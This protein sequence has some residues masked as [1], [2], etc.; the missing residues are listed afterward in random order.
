MA[1][2]SICPDGFYVYVHERNDSGSVFY[3]GKGRGKRA[4]TKRHYNS[5]WMRV[6]AK[7]GHTVRVVQS[8]LSEACAFSIERLMIY[9]LRATGAPLVNMTD[10]GEGP[11]GF[12]PSEETRLK[13]RAAKVGRKLAPEHAAKISAALR[14]K[15]RSQEQR[16]KLRGRIFSE[17]HKKA[18]SERATNRRMS[19]ESIAKM[20]LSKRGKKASEQTRA[21]NSAASKGEG[22]PH[23]SPTKHWFHHRVHGPRHCTQYALRTEFGLPH[24][25]LSKLV[26]GKRNIVAGWTM[27]IQEN[28]RNGEYTGRS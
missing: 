2:T 24:G 15:R 26:I 17:A 14:G 21:A 4:W 22:N 28:I 18:L 27:L 23:F 11:A 8:G 10:G 1:T 19:A 3:V 12:S 5:R 16:D 13:Q 9:R 25:N 7:H 6:D 20:A